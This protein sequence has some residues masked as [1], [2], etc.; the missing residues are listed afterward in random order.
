[1]SEENRDLGTQS[2][3]VRCVTCGS[4]EWLGGRFCSACGAIL[5]EISRSNTID[6]PVI[7]VIPQSSLIENHISASEA[8]AHSAKWGRWGGWAVGAAALLLTALVIEIAQPARVVVRFHTRVVRV[9]H[10]VTQA[11]LPTWRIG[12][13]IADTAS[14]SQ[15]Y[16]VDCS[17][18]HSGV[19]VSAVTSQYDC[20]Y[21]TDYSNS[22]GPEGTWV[23]RGATYYCYV[24]SN[25]ELP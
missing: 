20:P 13:C 2:P 23:V 11:P 10:Y 19:I 14:G 24:N 15:A 5:P 4:N 12:A 7:P 16:P 21:Y 25:I 3:T 22:Y 9:P 6:S 8:R 17:Q 1:M 18:P